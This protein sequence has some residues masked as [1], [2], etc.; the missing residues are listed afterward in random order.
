M[1]AGTAEALRLGIAGGRC[2]RSFWSQLH[3]I[4]LGHPPGRGPRRTLAAGKTVPA[5][6]RQAVMTVG[7]HDG[8]SLAGLGDGQLRG[9][10]GTFRERHDLLAKLVVASRSAE[11]RERSAG[12]TLRRPAA[13]V[14]AVPT[15]ENHRAAESSSSSRG[16][17]GPHNEPENG[18]RRS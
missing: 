1:T 15:A 5:L 17:C 3:R 10:L 7:L 12:C 18:V 8:T 4:G 14:G 9:A 13:V 6:Q 11:F 2:G 16:G